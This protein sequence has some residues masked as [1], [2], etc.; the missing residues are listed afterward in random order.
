M[1]TSEFVL[2]E[3]GRILWEEYDFSQHERFLDSQLTE[4]YGI[5]QFERYG[6]Q[7]PQLTKELKLFYEA[8]HRTGL[9]GCRSAFHHALNIT[10]ILHRNETIEVC[11]NWR[12]Y[13]V[14]NNYFLDNLYDLC[15]FDHVAFTGSASC[16][17]TFTASWFGL[18]NFYAYPYD[19]DGDGTTVL[20]TTTAGSHAERRGW[21]DIKK[22][23][24]RAR[25][26]LAGCYEIGKI[27]EHLKCI[28]FDTGE[29][30]GTKATQRDYRNGIMVVP[31]GQDKSG[32][33]AMDAIMG[34]KNKNVLWLV[35]EGPAMPVGILDART[36]LAFNP[37]FQLIM[38]GNANDKNDPHGTSCE[39]EGGWDSI[40]PQKDR[41]W[42]GKTMSVRFN[43]GEESPNDLYVPD[44]L[45]RERKDLPYNY[46]SNRFSR[47][48]T[49]KFSGNGDTEYGKTTLHYFRFAIG[50]WSASGVQQTVLSE[51]YVRNFQST[52]DPE[53]WGSDRRRT[54]AGFDPAFTSGGDDCALYFAETGRTILGK[55]QC[56]F[57]KETITI[58]P[59][60]SDKEE[61]RK[62][63]AR[64]VVG[65]CKNAGMSIED[66]G[67]DVSNDGGL[68]MQEIE[69]EWGERGVTGISSQG[70]SSSPKYQN[71]VSQY[72]MQTRELI[73]TRRTRGFNVASK[74]AKDLFERRYTSG[75][76]GA[77]VE[78]KKDMKKRIRRSPDAG[79][80]FAYC[81]F[82]IIRSGSITLDSDNNQ[83]SAE[84]KRHRIREL[85]RRLFN[86]R[87][88]DDEDSEFAGSYTGEE[89]GY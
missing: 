71:K 3:D 29:I 79:D 88:S 77:L 42:K 38:L 43:H 64:R 59:T 14:P 51:G 65:L 41:R 74:Y 81:C 10:Y 32:E 11:K 6:K 34:T 13:K 62:L 57:S 19:Q 37:L 68:M 50:F 44:H 36:N 55:E 53:I 86:Q 35:D 31:V 54:F 63:V 85:R 70:A 33:S 45:I 72:W 76:Q 78:P 40:N 87:D 18:M 75:K 48:D 8:K 21:G 69:K 1:S 58:N 7:I 82:M 28:V 83:I 26:D 66:L 5:K 61:Y 46:L 73:A 39:P 24:R 84:E 17:K 67:V 25:W 16:A 20:F 89:Y 15:Q 23:H 80:S 2:D 60:Q 47:E 52:D 27:V 12:G 56:I 30:E 9:K 49:A 4:N 22:L